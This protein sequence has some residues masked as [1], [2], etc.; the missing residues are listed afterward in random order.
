MLKERKD[1]ILFG[2]CVGIDCHQRLN[3][4]SLLALKLAELKDSLHR[5]FMSI[6]GITDV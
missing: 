5:A 3:R 2:Y 4:L 1:Y 6:D